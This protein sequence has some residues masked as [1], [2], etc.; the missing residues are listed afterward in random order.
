LK[1]RYKILII[2]PSDIVIVGIVG[3]MK[4]C[5]LNI[6]LS[7]VYSLQDALN[8]SSNKEFNLI[9]V[10]PIIFNNCSNALNKFLSRFNQTPIIEVITTYYDRN[11]CTRFVDCIYLNDNK[12]TIVNTITKHLT[13][14]DENNINK[15]TALTEREKDVLKLLAI[16]KSNKE[17]ADELYI[18]IHTVITHRKN[19]INKLGIKSAAAMAIYAV[20]N[21]II[22]LNDSLD[23]IK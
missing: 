9:L 4:S 22:G 2:E 21:N 16:G 23:L 15:E 14:K 7:S 12:E 3:E 11:L 20:A 13:L 1:N 17:I 19:I 5:N 6:D 18:S 10:N 8:I